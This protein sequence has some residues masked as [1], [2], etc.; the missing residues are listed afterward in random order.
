MTQMAKELRRT[1]DLAARQQL[2]FAMQRHAA[3]RQHDV[4]LFS[5]MLTG[6][7]QPYVKN[8]AP[9]LTFDSGSR[10]AALWLERYT[11]ADEGMRLRR[12]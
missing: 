2:V 5:A 4:C 10:V 12:A 6:S 3:E 7:W 11:A 8:F 1:K 9:N